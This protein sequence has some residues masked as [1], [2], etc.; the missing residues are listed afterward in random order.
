MSN[1]FSTPALFAFARNG[2]PE[3][4]VHG[5]SAVKIQG[6]SVQSNH[7]DVVLATRSLLKPWQFM[8]CDV[9]GH[10]PWWSIGLASHS[11][12]PAQMEALAALA[13]AAGA[14][15]SDLMCPRA[16]PLDAS[17]AASVRVSG[18]ALR[19]LHHPC[20]GKHLVMLA[21][22]QKFGWTKEQYWDVAHPLQRK[23]F[24]LVGKE[25][26]ANVVWVT[27]SCGL[28]NAAMS[29][30]AM[31]TMWEKLG[32]AHDEK[33]EQARELWLSNP[34]LVGG[35]RRLDSDLVEAS[36]RKVLVKEGADGLLVIQAL[37]DSQNAAA[38]CIVK[39]AGG[40]N[41]AYLAIAMWGLISRSE[42]LPK[43]LRE[44]GDYLRSRLEE[45][46]PRDQTLLLPPFAT[47]T[48]SES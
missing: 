17:V 5:I 20:A 33:T 1:I 18:Q 19:R 30:K 10:E 29:L 7:A 46:V 42:G 23:V 24:G 28:P 3:V 8:A 47:S 9:A 21:A 25:A 27:D 26:G 39:L 2:V 22:C 45:W 32:T 31:C 6:D 37:A 4:V 44:L 35:Q 16:M 34:R 38:T 12:Q 48:R 40:Y 15:E 36:G 41:P 13:E 43:V 11:G 14:E